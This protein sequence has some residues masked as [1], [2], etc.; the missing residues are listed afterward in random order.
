MAILQPVGR[1]RGWDRWWTSWMRWKTEIK[2]RRRQERTGCSVWPCYELSKWICSHSALALSLSFSS[3][4]FAPLS[5][6]LWLYCQTQTGVAWQCAS[7][8]SY[9]QLFWHILPVSSKTMVHFL[10]LESATAHRRLK[11]WGDDPRL[12][13]TIYSIF[14]L[15]DVWIIC[16][17]FQVISVK[18]DQFPRFILQ[19][20]TTPE[21][22]MTRVESHFSQCFIAKL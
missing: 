22:A 6:S 11:M 16:E 17:T 18:S 21:C 20:L 10:H 19:S 9:F 4:L 14:I 12:I 7:L 8:I 1:A 2:T 5:P 15:C 3:S 13:M